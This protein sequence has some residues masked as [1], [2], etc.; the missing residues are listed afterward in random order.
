M[1][2][3]T[4]TKKNVYAEYAKKVR[5]ILTIGLVASKSIDSIESILKANGLNSDDKTSIEE[6]FLEVLL[7]AD[8]PYIQDKDLETTKKALAMLDSV[9]TGKKLITALWDSHVALWSMSAND[10]PHKICNM[11]MDFHAYCGQNSM[12]ACIL[13]FYEAYNQCESF[14]WHKLEKIGD[15]KT[16][17]ILTVCSFSTSLT[18]FEITL[19]ENTDGSYSVA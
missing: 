17:T 6:G 19:R 5:K 14:E 16:G 12:D 3:S 7:D 10:S 11:I 15:I 8:I 4:S 1:C 9:D 2:N 18:E 13:A